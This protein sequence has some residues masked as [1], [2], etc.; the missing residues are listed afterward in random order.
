LTDGGRSRQP[1]AVSF[2]E[3]QSGEQF[4][5]VINHFKS[6]RPASSPQNNGND[7]QGDGQGSWNL[8]RTEAA[9]D[10]ANWLQTNPTTI[11]DSDVLI[12]GDLNANA[13]EDPLL[14]IQ[15]KGYTDLIQVFNGNSG[16][17]FV[18]DALS[19]SLDHALANESL[20]GQV[21]GTFEWHINTDEPSVIDYN[22]DFNPEGY[23]S[24]NPFRSSDHDPVIVGLNLFTP[25]I[26]T[27]LDGVENDND[28]CA[29]TPAGVAVNSDGCSGEQLV[30]ARCEQFFAKYP[31]IYLKCVLR[32][33]VSAYR[34]NLL[35]LSQAKRIYYRAIVR[36]FFSR[37]Y[38]R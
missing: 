35:S 5:A 14:A 20:A 3:L 4:T 22:T 9:N 2:E 10:L 36:V 25:A 16:Y 6:K 1:L 30:S 18:F 38:I 15:N 19:G 17:S 12:L 34:D 8:R 32:S 24:L 11:D 21:S 26:D 29:E 31:G 33:V 37:L 27:D 7:D 23:Y 13:E 28:L